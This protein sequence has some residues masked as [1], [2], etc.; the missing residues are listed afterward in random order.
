MNNYERQAIE[1][2]KATNTTMTVEFLETGKHFETDTH[3]R[4]IYKVTFKRGSRN[5]SLKFGQSLE[6]S[7]KWQYKQIP[8]RVF[9]CDGSQHS[10]GYKVVAKDV[11]NYLNEHCRKI[12]GVPPTAYDVLSR[13][14]KYDVGS[15]EDFCSEFGYDTD[16]RTGK[17]I[18]KDAVKEY[19]NV[20]KIWTDEE[21]EQLQEI[22]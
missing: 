19:N 14:Q 18:Y 1:F 7:T 11:Q 16:I 22:Q 21:V 15:F 17:K 3:A 12:E 6:D 5:F 4:D 10:G 8:S 9:Y 13:L 2:L 20:C